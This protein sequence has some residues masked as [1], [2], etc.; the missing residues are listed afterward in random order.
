[1]REVEMSEKFFQTAVSEVKKGFVKD[2]ATN[3]P[4]VL[5][6]Q[7]DEAKIA[8]LNY[9]DQD[10][11][12]M[13]Y[14]SIYVDGVP[15]R[16]CCTAAEHLGGYCHFCEYNAQQP[17][18]EK[19][20]TQKREDYCY[21]ILDDRGDT[22]GEGNP[23]MPK[24]R[25]RLSSPSD[26]KSIKRARTTA[27]KDMGRDGLRLSWLNVS[28]PKDQDKAPRIGVIGQI[29]GEVNEDEF[30]DGFL[31]P[32]TFDEIL[33]QFVHDSDEIAEL[34]KHYPLNSDPSGV[35]IREV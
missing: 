11:P 27:I 8:I 30:P 13:H 1:L 14:H 5:K 34:A 17:D 12:P 10:V 29:L 3:W 4:F 24:K 25:L 31:E 2:S 7:G 9:D 35:K 16:V 18:S 28:R 23:Y 32:F 15:Y 21:T 33:V 19:W 6:N 20:K 22:D 26:D